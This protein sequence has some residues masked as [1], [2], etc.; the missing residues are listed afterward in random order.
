MILKQV[1]SKMRNKHL[2]IV[3]H[4]WSK[5][6]FKTAFMFALLNY[7]QQRTRT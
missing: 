7:T 4:I 1:A 6:M 5:N 2:A 3:L